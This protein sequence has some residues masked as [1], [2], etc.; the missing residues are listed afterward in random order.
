MPRSDRRHTL[1]SR[2]ALVP[3]I[4]LGVMHAFAGVAIAG[5]VETPGG[6]AG[7]LDWW[8]EARFGM[9]IHWGPVSIKGTEI[10]WSRGGERRGIQGKGE[11]P[12]DV[13]D[14]LYKQFDPEQFNAAEW[15][16]VAHSAGMKYM[17][18][19]AKHCD[20]FCLWR[21]AVD[22]Y[23]MS[24]TPFRRDVCGELASAAQAAGMRIGW[25]YSPMDWRDP[26]CRTARNELYL[27]KMRG[28]L[29]EL[30]GNYG[31]IDLLWFDYDGGPNPWDQANTY[32][33]V[34]SLQPGLIIDDRL[35]LGPNDDNARNILDENSDYRTPE[36]RVGAFD[37]G[38]P[39]ET[40][41]TIGTQWSWKPDDRIKTAG[42]CIRILV[43]C[44]TG[45]GN[46]LLDV[47]PMPDGRI[48]PR[49]VEVLKGIGAWLDRYG[50]SIYGTRGGPFRNGIWG[51]ATCKGNVIYLHVANWEKGRI[52]L[53]ALDAKIR[54]YA[55]L[56]GGSVQVSQ[57]AGGTLLQAAAGSRDPFDTIIKLELDRSAE[58]MAPLRLSG[59][60][61]WSPG[62]VSARLTHPADAQY[63]AKG[64]PSLLDGE[65]GSTNRKDGAWLGFEGIDFEALYDFHAQTTITRVTIGCLQEQV[66]RIFF[67]GKIEIA[68]AGDDSVFRIA[69]NI[70]TGTPKEDA[71]IRS[72][73][74]SVSFDPVLARH[75]RVRAVNTGVCPP[76]HP[77]SGKKAWILVDETVIE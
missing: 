15:V 55:T 22:D 17:V 49:Q 45:D 24:A 68:V 1:V 33:L 14:N 39:W 58:A 28:H 6:K 72:S 48:E 42:E 63:P 7:R 56:T 44:V 61:R 76:W 60:S 65:R 77:E 51:G 46:L 21:S 32:A 13:Y 9:F 36:Q 30:M 5:G 25:Y 3:I 12:V 10:S 20:G 70:D 47:G 69:G 67:P 2:A 34:R 35:G 19:T 38:V 11:I 75:L 29:R 54:K 64:P 16:A 26:D 43:Q 41:M 23:C 52:L 8:R 59:V 4:L 74:F 62:S 50:E 66:S 18:L 27:Q 40:C 73:D 71:E 37:T 53:P 57:Q 31:R